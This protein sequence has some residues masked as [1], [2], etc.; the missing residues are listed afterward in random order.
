[1]KIEYEFFLRNTADR[2]SDFIGL[3]SDGSVRLQ[4]RVFSCTP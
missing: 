3:N 2:N 1:M 4:V